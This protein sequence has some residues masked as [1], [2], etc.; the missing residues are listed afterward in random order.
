M[1]LLVGRRQVGKIPRPPFVATR[2]PRI[3]FGQIVEAG[4]LNPGDTLRRPRGQRRAKV[5]ADGSLAVGQVT[6][7]IHKMGAIVQSQSACNGWT[8]WHIRTD[9]GLT[10]IDVLRSRVRAEMG[11]DHRS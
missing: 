5:R 8:Y 6:G 7:S 10:P 3:P 11:M 4:L 2:E 1:G 9:K